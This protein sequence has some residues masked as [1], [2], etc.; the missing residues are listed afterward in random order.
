MVS[1][2]VMVETDAGTSERLV[3]EIRDLDGVTEAHVVAGD[4]DL[5]VEVKAP[6]VYEVLKVAS[7]GIRPL[8]G[9]TDTR[10]YI[11]MD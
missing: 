6:E 3:E 2:F 11:A 5:I 1:A 10:T 9:V 7:D 4:Y 8:A